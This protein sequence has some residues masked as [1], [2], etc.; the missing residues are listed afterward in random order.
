MLHCISILIPVL[1]LL[2]LCLWQDT[3]LF[4]QDGL[5]PQCSQL[6]LFR[7]SSK[8]PILASAPQLHI[9]LLTIYQKMSTCKFQPL[10]CTAVF[11]VSLCTLAG[12][13]C[14]PAPPRGSGCSWNRQELFLVGFTCAM[15]VSELVTQMPFIGSGERQQFIPP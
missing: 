10:E 7:N 2:V 12:F 9:R 8:E 5:E 4:C 15:P 3:S 13:L 14:Q 1:I 11:R 6:T